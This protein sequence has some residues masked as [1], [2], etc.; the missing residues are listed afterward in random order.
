MEQQL[1]GRSLQDALALLQAKGIAPVRVVQSCAPRRDPHI[2][3]MR[4]VRIQE[5]G[6]LLT[7][8]AFLDELRQE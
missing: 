2:G 8:C 6:R 4:V 7:V 3:V 1:L 5:E